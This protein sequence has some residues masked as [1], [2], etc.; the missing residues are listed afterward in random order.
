MLLNTVVALSSETPSI[1]SKCCIWPCHGHCQAVCPDCWPGLRSSS[2]PTT[3]SCQLRGGFHHQGSA[4]HLALL[5][6]K[7]NYDYYSDRREMLSV[8][9]SGSWM[10]MVMLPTQSSVLTLL[11]CRSLFN[12]ICRG[13][14]Y[15]C[16]KASIILTSGRV[17]SFECFAFRLFCYQLGECWAKYFVRFC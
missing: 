11:A 9:Y 6:G 2:S 15:S 12:R 4:R 17:G 5:R 8:N 1:P 16:L 3:C 14:N 10:E 7:N 13:F